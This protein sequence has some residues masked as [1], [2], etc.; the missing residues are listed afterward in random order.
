M[1]AP[2]DFPRHS[3][4]NLTLSN[5]AHASLF[6]PHLL[7]VDASLWDTS[8]LGVSVRHLICGF[9]LFIFSSWLCCPLRFQ[10]SP[11]TRWWEGFPVFGNFSS[12]TTPSLGW[13]SIPNSFVSLFTFIFCPTSWAPGVLSQGSEVV[14]WYLLSIQMIFQ[15]IGGGKI[16]LPILFLH[17]LRT[18]SHN[19]FLLT[20]K[21]NICDPNVMSSL[22]C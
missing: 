15:W 11:K 7:V 14:L 3:G 9:Y 2:S 4:T 21:Q 13:V 22:N 1:L 19:S 6:S 17:H 18:T 20:Y 10:N 5:A 16:D 12:F 8:P